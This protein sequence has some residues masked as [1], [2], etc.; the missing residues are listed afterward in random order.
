MV[1]IS[2]QSG[3][4]AQFLDHTFAIVSLILSDIFR[5]H[6]DSFGV[7]VCVWIHLRQMNLAAITATVSGRCGGGY[8]QTI[9]SKKAI[10][11]GFI[12]T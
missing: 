1:F 9:A 12:F 2:K 5:V 7:C 6:P 8:G 11:K 3:S 10:L 4:S